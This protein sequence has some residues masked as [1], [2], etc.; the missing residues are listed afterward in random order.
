[1]RFEIRCGCNPDKLIGWIDRPAGTGKE[2]QLDVVDK[3]RPHKINLSVE[4][5]TVGEV[6]KRVFMAGGIHIDVLRMVPGFK[7]AAG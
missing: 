6:S 7:E 3:K 1:M 4:T 5:L 2:I